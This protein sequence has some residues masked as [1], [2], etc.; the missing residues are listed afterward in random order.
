M[1]A[2]VR[3]RVT[4]V[5]SLLVLVL[6]T[7]GSVLAQET[8]GDIFVQFTGVDKPSNCNDIG[9]DYIRNRTGDLIFVGRSLHQ[10]RQVP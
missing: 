4:F 1:L 10:R 3:E 2:R 7:G 8:R 5:I 9:M 6:V